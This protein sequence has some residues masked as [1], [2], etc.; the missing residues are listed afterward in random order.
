[1]TPTAGEL[2]RVLVVG[3]TGRLGVVIAPAL[4]KRSLLPK[5][6]GEA[7]ARELSVLA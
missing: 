2:R 1:M 7:K 6:R 5:A 3:A 4:V